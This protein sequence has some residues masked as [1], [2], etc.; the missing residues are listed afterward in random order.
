M[1]FAIQILPRESWEFMKFS[2]PSKP[3]HTSSVVHRSVIKVPFRFIV[4]KIHK[5]SPPQKDLESLYETYL[6]II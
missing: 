2:T 6:V 5:A 3:S 1:P 4:S